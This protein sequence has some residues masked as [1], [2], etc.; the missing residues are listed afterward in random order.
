MSDLS[1]QEKS[2]WGT[3]VALFVLGAL[4]FSSVWNLWRADELHLPA[5][6]GLGVGFTVLL[7]VVL[8]A[9][10]AVVAVLSRPE[11]E[12]ERDRLIGWRAGNAG[13]L[14]LGFLVVTIVLH[15]VV[16]GLVGRGFAHE[17]AESPALIS[18]SL[19]AALW[20]S[21]VVELALA[22]RYYRRGT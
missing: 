19:I 10:H 7:V 12:D 5:V 1:F 18:V 3:L 4:Y 20:L 2:A 13:G 15:I 22:V 16:G 8:I 11:D 21:T 6:F 17:L 14:V 9:Y